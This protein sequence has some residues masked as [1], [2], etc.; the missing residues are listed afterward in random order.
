MKGLTLA[1]HF[2]VSLALFIPAIA[3]EQS[4]ERTPSAPPAL[5]AA[6]EQ[7]LGHGRGP[8]APRRRHQEHLPSTL[9]VDVAPS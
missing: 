7:P 9:A 1:K 3:A 6:G 2:Q 8:T 5:A 4:L